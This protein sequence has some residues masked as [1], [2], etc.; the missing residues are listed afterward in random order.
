MEK[1]YRKVPP[2]FPATKMTDKRIRKIVENDPR[3]DA[4]AYR[5]VLEALTYTQ[6]SSPEGQRHVSG[7]E[8]LNGIKE[9]GL[10]TFGPLAGMVFSTWGIKETRDFGH[11]VFNLVEEGYMGDQEED[12]IEDFEDG[13]DLDNTFWEEYRNKPL[14]RGPDID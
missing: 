5:F 11:I 8:L 14:F 4:A 12:S 1:K 10:Q 13:F 6:Q 7:E 2:C 9:L 3:Y